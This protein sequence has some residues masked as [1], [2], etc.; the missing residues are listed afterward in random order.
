MRDDLIEL[1]GGQLEEIA[2]IIE[3][4]GYSAARAHISEHYTEAHTRQLLIHAVAAITQIRLEQRGE[5]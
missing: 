2:L 4:R 1:I 5:T 3:E